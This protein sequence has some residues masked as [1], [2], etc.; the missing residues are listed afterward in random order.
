MIT[1][2]SPDSRSVRYSTWNA[3]EG[4]NQFI[5][6]IDGGSSTPDNSI[7]KDLWI[8]K[9]SPDNVKFIFTKDNKLTE[10]WLVRN[11]ESV[12]ANK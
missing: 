6:P 3:Q 5:V 10:F 2:I 1:G 12:F 4:F 8:R 9:W 11:I 7:G